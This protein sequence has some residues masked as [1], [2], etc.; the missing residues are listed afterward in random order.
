VT[1]KS[2]NQITIDRL[3]FMME[4]ITQHY[5]K[6]ELAFI[7][8]DLLT[9]QGKTLVTDIRKFVLG[10]PDWGWPAVLEKIQQGGN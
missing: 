7:Q 9:T 1:V 2:P 6:P 8:S 3:K 4:T 10:D 5:N